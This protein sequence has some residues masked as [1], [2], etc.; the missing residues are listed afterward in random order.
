MYENVETN[1][2]YE[3]AKERP[4][5]TVCKFYECTLLAEV[6]AHRTRQSAEKNIKICEFGS[7]YQP[8]LGAFRNLIDSVLEWT[9]DTASKPFKIRGL[10]NFCVSSKED[11]FE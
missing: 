10:G 6:Q 5:S 11:G 1:I 7:Q 4:V 9:W 3:S 8:C 2:I